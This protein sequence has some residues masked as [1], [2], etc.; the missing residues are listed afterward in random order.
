MDTE[1]ARRKYRQHSSNAARR[2]IEMRLTFDEWC[3]IWQES[4]H[5]DER[6]RN[7]GQYCMARFGDSGH[8]ERGNVFIQR[9][10]TNSSDA[11]KGMPQTEEHIEKRMHP[12]RDGTLTGAHKAA[13]GSTLT[14]KKLAKSRP[15]TVDGITIFQTL[16]EL[17]L[18][19][20]RG[21]SGTKHPDFRFVEGAPGQF[22]ERR[23][24]NKN[25]RK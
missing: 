7:S 14:G 21:Y 1:D 23:G 18:A 24:G 5:W 9:T 20:G 13:I 25:W 16:K 2:G 4:G 17:Q 3:Q 22:K 11:T 19:L 12:Q 6:G 15:C 8:Y 10:N